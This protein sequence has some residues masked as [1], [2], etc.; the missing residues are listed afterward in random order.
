MIPPHGFCNSVAIT[1]NWRGGKTFISNRNDRLR[2][3]CFM[4]DVN[5]E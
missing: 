5:G 4:S 3:G 1:A 2:S